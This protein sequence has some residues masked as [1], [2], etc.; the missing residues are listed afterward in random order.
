MQSRLFAPLNCLGK[1]RHF[2]DSA[3]NDQ[4]KK[5][6]DICA[7][8]AWNCDIA[9]YV[10]TGVPS[11]AP[12]NKRY[13][14]GSSENAVTMESAQDFCRSNTSRSWKHNERQVEPRLGH[15]KKY[16]CVGAHKLR[17]ET[18]KLRLSKSP[19]A[20]QFGRE[21]HFFC[22]PTSLLDLAVA[23]PR[24]VFY[25]APLTLAPAQTLLA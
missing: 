7:S 3:S 23:H 5:R 16:H 20:A 11:S 15:M 4:R 14:S 10:F 1:V 12:P 19:L 13:S 2:L 25:Q 21:V 17:C 6:L 8:S 24:L 9:G 18:E 22:F